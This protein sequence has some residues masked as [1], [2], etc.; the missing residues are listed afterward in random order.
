MG[1]GD[2]G[3]RSALARVTMVDFD[4]RVIYDEHVRPVERVTGGYDGE[5]MMMMV[6][7]LCNEWVIHFL[8]CILPT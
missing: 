7:G 3:T 6:M 8:W 4:G 2:G 1:V 5:R